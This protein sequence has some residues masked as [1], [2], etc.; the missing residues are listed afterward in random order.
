MQIPSELRMKKW[1]QSAGELRRK[2]NWAVYGSYTVA[3]VSTT[4]LLV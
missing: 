3:A 1:L 4:P 2:R